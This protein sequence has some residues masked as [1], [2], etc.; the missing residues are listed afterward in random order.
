M[1]PFYMY[2]N[3]AVPSSFPQYGAP[4][5]IIQIPPVTN[6]HT[7]STTNQFPAA[8]K[9]Q[10]GTGNYYDNITQVG[11]SYIYSCIGLFILVFLMSSVIA[12]LKE[13]AILTFELYVVRPLANSEFYHFSTNES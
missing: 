9:L 3:M 12:F 10:Y 1:P 5:A 6:A 7:G 8:P 2:H 13:L 11:V 4:T